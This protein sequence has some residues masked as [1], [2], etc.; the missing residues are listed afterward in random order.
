MARIRANNSS[1]GGGGTINP[2]LAN[3]TGYSTSYSYTIDLTKNYIF[4]VISQSQA[5]NALYGVFYVH[6]TTVTEI[7][8][9]LSS[10]T[11]ATVK[12]NSSGVLSASRYSSVEQIK[13][14]LTQ[15]D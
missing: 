12:V 3:Q 8:S 13:C 5:Q 9:D 6:G 11:K 10:Q 15:L 2:T 14:C 7:Y 1:G 4:T